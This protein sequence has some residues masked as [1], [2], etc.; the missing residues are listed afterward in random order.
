MS[1]ELLKGSLDPPATT[2]QFGIP[3]SRS[4]ASYERELLQYR[5]I[6]ALLRH[7]LVRERA[8]L[9]EKN[10]QLK[11]QALLTRE[12]DHRLLNDLQIVVSLLSLQSRA[13]GNAEIAKPLKTAADRV[14]MIVRLHQRLHSHDGAQTVAFKRYLSELCQDFS[15]MTSAERALDLDFDTDDEIELPAATAISLGFIVSELLT[16]AAKHGT[17][18]I[19]VKFGANGEGGC[20]LSVSNDGPPLPKSFDPAAGKGLGMM[21]IRS[22]VDRIGGR[23]HS[24]H[25]DGNQGACFTVTFA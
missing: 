14:G 10:M 17:G 22:F 5:S 4:V 15:A 25:C 18:R 21:I 16:N 11:Q 19:M 20:E 8:L 2:P 3:G 12:S 6:E 23:L 7:A 13:A 1:T 9:S 24:S